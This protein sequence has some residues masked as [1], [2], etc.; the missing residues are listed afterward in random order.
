MGRVDC[1]NFKI[2]FKANAIREFHRVI[3]E[4]QKGFLKIGDL[5]VKLLVRDLEKVLNERISYSGRMIR[6]SEYTEYDYYSAR[7]S[8]DEIPSQILSSYGISP[9]SF[10]LRDFDELAHSWLGLESLSDSINVHV[11][12]PV[13]AKILSVQYQ[14]GSEVRARAWVFV[15]SRLLNK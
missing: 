8:M 12:F 15:R 2:V 13:Y 11:I 6:S 5:S 10:G 1:G 9:S 7:L 14:G 4:M 3:E